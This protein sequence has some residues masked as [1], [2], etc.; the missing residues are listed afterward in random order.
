MT[1]VETLPD[2]GAPKQDQVEVITNKIV[3][4][5]G[6]VDLETALTVICSLAGQVVAALS[7]G[8]PSSIQA[9]ADSLASN[10]KKAAIIKMLHDDDE[11]RRNDV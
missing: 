8:R 3:V 10:I 11:R 7:E 6:S 4:E 2:T 5:L 9:H 1:V